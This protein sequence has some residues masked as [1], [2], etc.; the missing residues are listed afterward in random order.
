ML[1]TKVDNVCPR[2]SSNKLRQSSHQ[3]IAVLHRHRD[4]LLNQEDEQPTV[5]EIVVS[6]RYKTSLEEL[7]EMVI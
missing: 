2:E 3:D 6:S 1:Q 5:E 7:K 4:L